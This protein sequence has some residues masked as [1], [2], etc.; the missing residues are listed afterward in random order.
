MENVATRK[1][2]I[3]GFSEFSQI[4]VDV[5]NK[6]KPYARFGDLLAITNNPE[7]KAIRQHQA[8][9]EPN[10]GKSNDLIT[11]DESGRP[12]VTVETLGQLAEEQRIDVA[13]LEHGNDPQVRMDLCGFP[14]KT[15]YRL[16]FM[17]TDY[18]RQYPKAFDAVNQGHW[19]FIHGP[20]GTRKTSFACHMA[21]KYLEK[22]PARKAKFISI[23]SW[24]AGMMPDSE[25]EE[26]IPLPYLPPFVILDDLEKYQNTDWQKLQLFDLI[27]HLYRRSD[28]FYVVITSNKG[29][30]EIDQ[31]APGC[32]RIGPALDRIKEMSLQIP[33]TGP[34]SR[35]SPVIQ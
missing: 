2:R 19:L 27:D 16:K 6:E 26:A 20:R 7:L 28:D 9:E 24:L 23:K 34:S 10:N 31:Q 17:T 11:T 29:L 1:K 25:R 14:R 22:H 12:F 15:E 13:M 3:P 33:L 32:T 8:V 4:D 21:W 5:D 30:K 18:Q 35:K